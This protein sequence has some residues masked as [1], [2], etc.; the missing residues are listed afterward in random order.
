MR[1]GVMEFRL[2]AASGKK[3]TDANIAPTPQ[4]GALLQSA[5]SVDQNSRR[6]LRVPQFWPLDTLSAEPQSGRCANDL[7]LS[8]RRLFD[9]DSAGRCPATI[10]AGCVLISGPCQTPSELWLRAAIAGAA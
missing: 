4:D 8:E 10:C 1:K 3:G 7:S 9:S 2:Q 6:S 5:G